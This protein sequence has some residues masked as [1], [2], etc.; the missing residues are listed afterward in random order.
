L[1]VNRSARASSNGGRAVLGGVVS[2]RAAGNSGHGREAAIL[3]D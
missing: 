2:R 3:S 1:R